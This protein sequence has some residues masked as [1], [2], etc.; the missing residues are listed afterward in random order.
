MSKG[1]FEKGQTPWNN[2][3]TKYPQLKDRE[4]LYHQYVEKELSSPEISAILKCHP[5]TVQRALK[6][7]NTRI[8]TQSELMSG[9]NNPNYGKH[10]TPW[11]KGKHPSE[12]TLRKMSDNQTD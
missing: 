10:T 5:M 7:A 8:R 3:Q 9:K 4:W 2:G 6:K 12:E 1:Q 11:N